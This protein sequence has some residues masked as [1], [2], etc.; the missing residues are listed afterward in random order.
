ML[1]WLAGFAVGLLAGLIT[2]SFIFQA[3]KAQALAEAAA[4]ARAEIAGLLERLRLKEQEAQNLLNREQQSLQE[5]KDLLDQATRNLGDAFKALSADALRSNNQTFLELAG[6]VLGKIQAQA[7]GDLI[8]RQKELE[9]LVLPVNEMLGKYQ[10]QIQSI[11]KARSADYGSL[12]QQLRLLLD[13]EQKIQK[14]T[15]NLV[16]ALRTPSIRGRWGEITLRR[17]VELAGMTEY[18][19]FTEQ[20][21]LRGEGGRLRPDMIVRL[22][23]GKTLVLD[24]KVPLKAYL[25]ALEAT[26]DNARQ[27]CLQAHARQIRAHL[28]SLSNKAY[29]E[30][31]DTAP[32]FVIMF[33]PGDCFYSAAIERDPALFEE[34][35][36]RRVIIATP[37]SLIPLMLTIAHGWRQEKLAGNAQRISVL[38]KSLYERLLT[39][40]DHFNEIGLALGRAVQAYNQA[41]G[42]MEH[43]VL[44]AA[45]RFSELGTPGGE[46]ALE[47]TPIDQIPRTLQPS[48]MRD[49]TERNGGDGI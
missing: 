38:G 17:V 44:V 19:D 26:E 4:A 36:T 24:S 28:Q 25:E 33:I 32:E 2:A 49:S 11:E 31:M 48:D 46:E 3:K 22:P 40:T 34:G 8:L 29:W 6:T 42:S 27:S 16:N 23:A 7:S 47:L 43:R 13:S 21:P 41:V 37:T 35:V 18:C 30:Q 14:E 9:N 39:L 15:A 5:K 45:R 12:S 1:G 10:D 20:E